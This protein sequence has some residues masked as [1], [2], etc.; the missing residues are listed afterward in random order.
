MG[1]A[2]GVAV[3][4]D[5]RILAP[6]KRLVVAHTES[7]QGTPTSTSTSTTL[8][9]P[10]TRTAP[11]KRLMVAHTESDQGTPRDTEG[12]PRVTQVVPLG[13]C[14]VGLQVAPRYPPA[15]SA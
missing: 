2:R 4:G 14:Q 11:V 6:V 3:D 10:V 1:T 15:L 7:D 12:A 13:H 5:P 8:L 9:V